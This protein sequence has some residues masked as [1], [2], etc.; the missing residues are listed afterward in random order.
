MSREINDIGLEPD[1]TLYITF[2]DTRDI[3]VG[4]AVA[5]RQTLRIAPT[6]DYAEGIQRV[7][8]AAYR[9]LS[10]ALADHAKSEPVSAEE[11]EELG[12]STTPR[13]ERALVAEDEDQDAAIRNWKA[14]EESRATRS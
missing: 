11:L 4:G 8:D 6:D 3:R 1:G 2:I 13:E 10:D 7:V 12:G 9:L 14:I 5:L